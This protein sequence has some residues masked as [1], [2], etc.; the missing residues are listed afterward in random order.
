MLNILMIALGAALGGVLRH[1]ATLGITRIMG[2]DFP[3]GTIAVNV[4]GSF[5]MG[6]LIVWLSTHEP[7]SQA[8]RLFAS[9]GVLGAFTTFSTLSLDAYVLLERGAYGSAFIYIFGSFIVGLLALW[10]GLTVSRSV[11]L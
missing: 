7:H 9:V 10:V 6:V 8:L 2:T 11:W 4:A 1:F 3:Y 5:L